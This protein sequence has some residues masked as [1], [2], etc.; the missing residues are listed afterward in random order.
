M[1][2]LVR[3]APNGVR[4]TTPPMK[5]TPAQQNPVVVPPANRRKGA[6]QPGEPLAK[7]TENDVRKARALYKA[8]WTI[9]ALAHG[10]DVS[11]SNMTSIVHRQTWRHVEDQP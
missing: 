11:T 10:F 4:Y 3:R 9:S 8:G 5:P 6:R 1:R 7:L 2:P